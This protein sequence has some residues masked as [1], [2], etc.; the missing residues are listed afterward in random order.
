ML[1]REST[2]SDLPEI[3]RLRNQVF[4]EKATEESFR[5]LEA[6][7][8]DD[9]RIRL[10]SVADGELL[11]FGEVFRNLWMAPGVFR[12]QLVVDAARRGQGIGSAMF[13]PL[14]EWANAQSVAYLEATP[15]DQD[16]SSQE[17]LSRKGFEFHAHTFESVLD[18]AAFDSAAFESWTR[19]ELKIF[20]FAETLDDEAARRKL[21]M[22]NT[23]TSRDEPH[24]DPNHVPTFEEYEKN[25]IE[26]RW[27]NPA[28]QFIAAIGEEWV[29][30]S[31]VGTMNPGT[32]LNFFTGVVR[33]HRGLGLAKALKLRS[34]TF[35]KQS[36][37]E[38]LRTNND[39]RNAPML[40]INRKMGYQPRVG[41]VFMR[42]SMG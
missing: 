5:A 27:F 18:L 3:V 33:S 24:N 15:S 32:M 29:A 26:A 6:S 19:P 38:T 34:A 2:D 8:R 30:M 10:V 22:L 17:F 31:A 35:A 39:S 25:V 12:L 14:A 23:E 1:I 40:A 36:G 41:W 21:W 37:A 20:S 9:P 7:V 13:A 4:P 11:G 28:G 16:P 42:R